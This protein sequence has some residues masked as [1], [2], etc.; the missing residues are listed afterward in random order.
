M[1]MNEDEKDHCRVMHVLSQDR[2]TRL[3]S[4]FTAKVLPYSYLKGKPKQRQRRFI[5]TFSRSRDAVAQRLQAFYVFCVVISAKIWHPLI[6]YH[7]VHFA[8]DFVTP[9]VYLNDNF[10]YPLVYCKPPLT[11]HYV[12][13]PTS[14]PPERFSIGSVQFSM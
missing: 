4:S 5:R 13:Y 11:A 2:S 9:S 8:A 10:F 14:P 1:T 3:Q 12:D 7:F 6:Y